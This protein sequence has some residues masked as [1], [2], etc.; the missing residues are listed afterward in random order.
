MEQL[1]YI[2]LTLH[3]YS[4]FNFFIGASTDSSSTLRFSAPFCTASKHSSTILNQLNIFQV[5]SVPSSRI[6]LNPLYNFGV[7]RGITSVTTD[8]HDSQLIN[9][10]ITL[11]FSTSLTM[12]CGIYH[13]VYKRVYKVH[14][15]VYDSVS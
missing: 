12:C 13:R 11:G 4:S 14:R 1:N 6:T 3:F 2:R 15:R 7:L 5:S 9:D 10:F 8:I